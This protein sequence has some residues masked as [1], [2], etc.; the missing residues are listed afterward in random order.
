MNVKMLLIVSLVGIA[1]GAIILV[2]IIGQLNSLIY[3]K[4]L[5]A[6]LS[7]GV[8][9]NAIT[10]QEEEYFSVIISSSILIV[11]SAVL[12]VISLRRM[13]REK[14]TKKRNKK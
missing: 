6:S 1:A 8:S 10:T 9:Q 12:L 14:S 2:L 3:I 5:S 13:L 7:L 4:N 11:L